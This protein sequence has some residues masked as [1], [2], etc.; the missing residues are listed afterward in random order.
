MFVLTQAG[1]YKENLVST[2]RVDIMKMITL[3]FLPSS[4]TSSTLPIAED[5]EED[6]DSILSTSSRKAGC[7]KRS[8]G[9][10][11]GVSLILLPTWVLDSEMI[12][13]SHA[14]VSTCSSLP[15]LRCLLVWVTPM[16]RSDGLEI[17]C[18][19]TKRELAFFQC[20]VQY[21]HLRLG[22]LGT[23]CVVER[24]ATPRR[25]TIRD[26]IRRDE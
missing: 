3:T 13:V 24:S 11:R 21:S 19:Y 15:I 16:I 18:L 9:N 22:D 26:E 6:E 1:I 2:A 23:V 10:K 14:L 8:T 25:D 7:S 12:F 17:L 5:E 20:T 4:A